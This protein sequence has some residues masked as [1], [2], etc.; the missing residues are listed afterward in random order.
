M[1]TRPIL[2]SGPMVRAILEGRKTQ[3]RRVVK[4]P[5]PSNEVGEFLRQL[6]PCRRGKY[7]YMGDPEKGHEVSLKPYAFPGE[8][9]WV[10][11]TWADVNNFG[12]EAIA[13]RAD[14]DVINVPKDDDFKFIPPVP[15][16][17]WFAVWAGDLIAGHEKGWH[18]SIHMPRWASRITLE[19]TGIRVER[20]QDIS[21]ADARAE[22]VV[23]DE[24][25]P[26]GVPYRDTFAF[27]WD[28]ING[29]KHPWDSNPWV[30][31][32]DF[33]SA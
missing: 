8:R 19:V 16:K 28:F 14:G 17:W 3:T 23:P 24:D 5:Q 9:L 18:P 33:R 11:E 6:W 30:W 32:V 29:K 13:Y 20:V 10:R 26:T 22:G 7:D 25:N 31:V 12:V 1:K 2:F 21:E 4:T 27:V 15:E